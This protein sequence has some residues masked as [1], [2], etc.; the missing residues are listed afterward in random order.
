[1]KYAPRG[2]AVCLLFMAAAINV[3]ADEPKGFRAE[4]IGQIEYAQKQVLDLENAI[5]DS[6]MSWR[7]TNDVRSISEVYS[8]IAF[9][10]YLLA[11]MAGIAPPEGVKV[12]SPADGSTWEKATMDKKAIHDQLVK[13]FDH[14]KNGISKMSD[15]GLEKQVE[16]FGQ[17]M[18]TRSLLMVLLGHMHEHLGQSIAYARMNGI[19]PPWTAAQQ[20]AEKTMK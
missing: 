3:R 20:A 12:T 19:V 1:M 13:S 9:S 10:N 8:H 18:T 6:K 7:P 16:F 15:A 14:I 5:P 17:K 4:L 2:L 11:S